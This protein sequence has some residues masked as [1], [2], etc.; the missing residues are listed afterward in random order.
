MNYFKYYP[1][2]LLHCKPAH[3]P[4]PNHT[5]RTSSLS[6]WV[7]SPTLSGENT[8][9]CFIFMRLA[10]GVAGVTVEVALYFLI[11]RLLLPPPFS[12]FAVTAASLHCHLALLPFIP[13]SSWLYSSA[14]TRALF[15]CV[16]VARITQKLAGWISWN[17]EEM[18][19]NP[20]LLPC[21]K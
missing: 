19:N 13:C 8:S 21:V 4:D 1:Q 7:K 12:S 18:W 6:D 11:N 10:A 16:F 15:V 5:S 20:L 3:H 14:N 17:L 9:C 2:Y